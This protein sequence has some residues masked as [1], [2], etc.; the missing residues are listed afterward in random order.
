MTEHISYGQAI[1]HVP[2]V[3][4]I[5][6]Y[7]AYAIRIAAMPVLYQG[8]LAPGAHLGEWLQAL[9]A[10]SLSTMLPGWALVRLWPR[11]RQLTIPEQMALATG[12]GMALSPVLLLLTHLVGL[13]LGSLYAWLPPLIALPVLFWTLRRHDQPIAQE[14]WRIRERGGNVWPNIALLLVMIAIIAVRYMVV[15][16]LEIPVWGDSLHHTMIAQLIIDQGGLFRSW[17]PYASMQSFTYHFGFHSQVANLVWLTGSKTARA[18]VLTGQIA[19]VASVFTLYP[20]ALRL[21]RS[22]WAGVIALLLAGLLAPMPMFYVNWG[23]YTQLAGQAILPVG[24]YLGWEFLTARSFS[25]SL[26]GLT[27]LTLAG[28]TL[29]HYRIAVFAA[30]F[31]PAFALVVGIQLPWR[32]WLQR[33]ALIALGAGVLVLPWFIQILGGKLLTILLS[34]STSSRTGSS[35]AASTD[36]ISAVGDPYFFLP[37]LIWYAMLLSMFWALWQRKRGVLLIALWWMSIMLAV[38]PQWLRLP[39]AGTLTNFALIIA[40]YIP[41]ALL[42]GAAVGWVLRRLYVPAALVGVTL[43][44]VVSAGWGATLRLKD[45]DFSSSTMVTRA[46][47]QAAAW[48]EANTPPDARFLINGFF[49]NPEAVVGSDGGWWLPLLAHRQTTLPPLLYIS[50]QGP[51]PDYRTWINQVYATINAHGVSSPE[52]LAILREHGVSHVYI[53]Q[54]QGRVGYN[55]ADQMIGPEILLASPYFRQVYHQDHVWIFALQPDNS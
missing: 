42:I 1:L 50:E 30:C 33:S 21:G 8:I 49:P 35:S 20:L 41:A 40:S 26:L 27:C 6:N 23:R 10:A 43:V 9:L 51:Q 39:G 2:V 11:A 14:A 32:T 13:N 25:W 7:T 47:Q 36:E 29:T 46:D 45:V 28:M 16:D 55:G 54:E 17:E 44:I 37:A 53:G 3:V 19:N 12:V 52:T 24:I 5:L 48:I 31:F 18:V 4:F 34:I 15:T 38:N 22:R